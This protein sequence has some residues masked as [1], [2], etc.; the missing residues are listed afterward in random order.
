MSIPT[1]LTSCNMPGAKSETLT[2][3]IKGGEYKRRFLKPA[4]LR[5]VVTI[6]ASSTACRMQNRNTHGFDLFRVLL[7]NVPHFVVT[8]NTTPLS[9]SQRS[10]LIVTVRFSYSDRTSVICRVADPFPYI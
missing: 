5:Q 8:E 3:L 4:S 7:N 9:E 2:R 1:F 10:R 6:V